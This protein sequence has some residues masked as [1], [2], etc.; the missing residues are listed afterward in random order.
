MQAAYLLARTNLDRQR[1]KKAC[2]LFDKERDSYVQAALAQLLVQRRESNQDVVRMLALHAN[3][4]VRGIGKF[5]RTVKTKVAADREA[6]RHAF[7]VETPYVLCDVMPLVHLM[8]S[9][10]NHHI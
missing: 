8:A 7:R 3:D 10:G 1:I 6:L 5:F 9:S 4:K 2:S